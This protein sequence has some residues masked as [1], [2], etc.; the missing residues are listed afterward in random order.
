MSVY[1]QQCRGVGGFSS[2]RLSI[3]Q[4]SDIEKWTDRDR[5]QHML[6]LDVLL[7]NTAAH[8]FPVKQTVILRTTGLRKTHLGL[9]SASVTWRM[10][11]ASSGWLMSP[12]S[13]M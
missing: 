8:R 4:L 6:Q 13:C 5:D 2:S 7:V 9:V 1:S 3:F 10:K 12:F 11:M